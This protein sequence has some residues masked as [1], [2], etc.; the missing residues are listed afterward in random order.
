[1][2]VLVATA[3]FY[4]V[5]MCVWVFIQIQLRD[6]IGLEG[7]VT[8]LSFCKRLSL[9]AFQHSVYD[10]VLYT[11]IIIICDIYIAPYSARS[12]SKSK[13][14]TILL[15]LTQTCFHPAHISTP[16]GVYNTY[17]HYRCKA[18]LKHLAITS[19]QVLI[20]YGWVNQSPHNSI[21]AHGA[22]NLRPFG[23][24]SY[25]LTK[26]AITARLYCFFTG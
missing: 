3:Y 20:F 9:R 25:A 14:F 16:R 13:G 22:L 24:E 8:I 11:V 19:C 5:C 4:S 15:S 23:Y 1:M 17:G 10:Y 18:L 2:H 6:K 7:V 26:C 12:C 21:A